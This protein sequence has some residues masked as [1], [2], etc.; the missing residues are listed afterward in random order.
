MASLAAKSPEKVG[1]ASAGDVGSE[2]AG[3][4]A[5]GAALVTG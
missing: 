2:P 1:N 3:L 5:R 4:A